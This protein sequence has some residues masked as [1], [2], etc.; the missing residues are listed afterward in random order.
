MSSLAQEGF[1]SCAG[2]L[3]GEGKR[4]GD[5]IIYFWH[6]TSETIL[7]LFVYP[8]NE[9]GDLTPAQRKALRVMVEKEYP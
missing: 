5:R 8:K 4:G 1:E 3:R 6:A 2:G 7:L 9:R